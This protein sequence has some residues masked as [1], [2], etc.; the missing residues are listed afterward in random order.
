MT[1]QLDVRIQARAEACLLENKSR[2]GRG[3]LAVLATYDVNHLAVE[4]AVG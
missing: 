4:D 2:V 3:S 1:W